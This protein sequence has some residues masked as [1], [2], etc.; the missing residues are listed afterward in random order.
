MDV[1]RH[2]VGCGEEIAFRAARVPGQAETPDELRISRGGEKRV[3]RHAELGPGGRGHLGERQPFGH[4]EP[5]FDPA[6]PLERVDH[7]APAAARRQ[8]VDA[9]LE[10]AAQPVEACVEGEQAGVLEDVV[11]RERIDRGLQGGAGGDGDGRALAGGA[12]ATAGRERAC[13]QKANC[14]LRIAD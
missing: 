3:A 12:C 4:D 1:Q 14:G 2:E 8:Q 10:R 6:T 9:A 11:G 5:R 7:V 13:E